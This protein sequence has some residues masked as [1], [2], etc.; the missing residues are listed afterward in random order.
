MRKLWEQYLQ[1]TSRNAKKVMAAM[2][3]LIGTISLAKYFDGNKKAAFWFL[4]SGAILDFLI[5]LTKENNE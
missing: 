1:P 4:V 3:T 5:G 2:K